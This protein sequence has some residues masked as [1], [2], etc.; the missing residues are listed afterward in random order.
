MGCF[1]MEVEKCIEEIKNEIDLI[2]E[3]FK[4]HKGLLKRL[5]KMAPNRIELSAAATVLHSF[6]NGIE[7]IF[8]RIANRIDKEQPFSEYWHQELLEQLKRKTSKRNA[9]IS[10]ELHEKLNLY[11]GF[12]HFFRHSY[13][14][15]FK[16]EKMSE[17]IFELDAVY[18][19]F[20]SEINQ[21]I[22][23]LAPSG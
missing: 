4:S 14:F 22:L 9:V 20:K 6:Y 2:D 12:R 21:F 3:L 8:I 10:E 18:D 15:H 1:F 11:L 13:A 5:K 16:W 17:L 19:Q 23:S 7:N